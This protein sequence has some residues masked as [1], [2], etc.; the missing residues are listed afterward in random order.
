MPD[1]AGKAAAVSFIHFLA[2]TP[3]CDRRSFEDDVLSAALTQMTAHGQSGLATA[4]NNRVDIISLVHA[5]FGVSKEAAA[6]GPVG[7]PSA[8]CS[9]GLSLQ[10]G[11][12][13]DSRA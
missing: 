9:E 6:G 5:H 1:L 4:N 2:K 11:A 10:R 8:P 3:N 7:T 12:K 13:Y